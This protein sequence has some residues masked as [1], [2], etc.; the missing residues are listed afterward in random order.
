[1]SG[2]YLD[3]SVAELIL[4]GE[5]WSRE[6]GKLPHYMS[7][8][9][10]VCPLLSKMSSHKS[11]ERVVSAHRWSVDY[12]PGKGR[13]FVTPT[14]KVEL[15]SAPQANSQKKNRHVGRVMLNVN[16]LFIVVCENG[17]GGRA[18]RGGNRRCP[19]P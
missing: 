12:W 15:L 16:L 19:P 17:V 13:L 14:V 1:M 9:Q 10:Y 6:P 5:L 7:E 18:D 3:T 2:Y 8:L 4:D 11:I